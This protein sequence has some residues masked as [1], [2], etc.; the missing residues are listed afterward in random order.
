MTGHQ[1]AVTSQ[2]GCDITH[3]SAQCEGISTGCS[4]PKASPTTPPNNRN[5]SSQKGSCYECGYIST[6][7]MTHV[8]A[9]RVL[10]T[11]STPTP[12]SKTPHSGRFSNKTGHPALQHGRDGLIPVRKC[13]LS[14]LELINLEPGSCALFMLPALGQRMNFSPMTHLG[15]VCGVFSLYL[16]VYSL[17]AKVG[18]IAQEVR[19]IV[20][21]S[22][23]IE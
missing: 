19:A 9:F 4:G 2:A 5:C 11:H 10:P 23:S 16:A 22:A 6:V 13:Y 12:R 1:A 18:R 20:W 7:G 3:S 21:Q 14:N 8:G 15:K 17:M